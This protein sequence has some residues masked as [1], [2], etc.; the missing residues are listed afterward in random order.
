M[1]LKATMGQVHNVPQQSIETEDDYAAAYNANP[2]DTAYFDIV[3]NCVA[4]ST[5][6]L[7]IGVFLEFDVTFED[8]Y[9]VASS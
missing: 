6:T 2:V 5:D 8:P 4:A 9:M 7:T 1:T 3:G